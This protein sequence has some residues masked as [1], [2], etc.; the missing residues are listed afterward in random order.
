MYGVSSE[1]QGSNRFLP[2]G[3]GSG[4]LKRSSWVLSNVGQGSVENSQEP[5]SLFHSPVSKHSNFVTV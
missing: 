1:N 5:G 2:T 3:D 4:Q